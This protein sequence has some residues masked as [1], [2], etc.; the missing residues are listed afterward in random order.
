MKKPKVHSSKLVF[1][2]FFN[3]RVDMLEDRSG[4]VHPYSSLILP[5]D[6]AAIL[7]QDTEGRWI[8]NRE[9]RHPAG[10]FL[11]GCPGGRLEPGEDPVLGGQRELFE[12]TGY[13]SDEIE[14]IGCSHPF[15][16]IC[17]QKLYYLFAKNS[18]KKGEQ[19]LDPFERIEVELKTDEEL[20]KAIRSSDRIDAILCAALWY[21]EIRANNNPMK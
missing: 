18:V 17:N 13:W 7:A 6:A 11:L 2:G 1:E 8:L 20:K 21:A 15:P 3:V 19:R 10:E 4:G 9:Y 14:V 5:T 12:E 16:G